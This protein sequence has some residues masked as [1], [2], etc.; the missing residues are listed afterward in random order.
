[1]NEDIKMAKPEKLDTA[2]QDK[3]TL[4][5]DDGKTLTC[6]VLQIY[7]IDETEYIAL[8]PENEKGE[9][10][11]DA[12]IFL[13]R[14]KRQGDDEITLENIEDD[15]EFELASDYFSEMLDEEE[16]ESLF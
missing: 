1:M 16:F 8:L 15:E 6:I 7:S 12:Q 13:Y 3:M 11:D 5:L 2:G 10:E 9:V 14:L 4:D